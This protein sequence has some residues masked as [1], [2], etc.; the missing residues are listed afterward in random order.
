MDENNMLTMEE[1]RFLLEIL[2][3]S[4][5]QRKPIYESYQKY[6]EKHKQ[7]EA[8]DSIEVQKQTENQVQ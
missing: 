3:R 6:I 7:F 1:Q 4:I 8:D 2:R 5:T